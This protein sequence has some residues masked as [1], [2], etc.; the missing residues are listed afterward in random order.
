MVMTLIQDEALLDAAMEQFLYLG[1]RR[2]TTDD[3]AKAAGV[4]RATLYRRLGDKDAIIRATL[5]RE[6]AGFIEEIREYV[7]GYDT[8]EEQMSRG[9]ARTVLGIREHPLVRRMLSLQEYDVLASMTVDATG[10]LDLGVAFISQLV[11]ES[12][13]TFGVR[14]RGEASISAAMVARLIHSLALI[15]GAQPEL[16]TE[17]ELRAFTARYLLPTL[18][19]GTEDENARQ[20]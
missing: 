14:L 8:F 16:A 11:E 3:I 2:T 13:R 7:A 12:V 18:I 6:V 4:N 19:V 20:T 5:L 15:P 1:L 9:F 10:A 17:D